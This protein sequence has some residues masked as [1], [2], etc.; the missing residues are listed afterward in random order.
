M[1]F[2]R[3]LLRESAFLVGPTA[4]GKSDLALA[5]A[6][7]LR[8]AGRPVEIVALDSMTLYR[9]LDI[10]TAKP[11]PADRADFPHHLLDLVDPSEEF[12]VAT[13]VA[14]AEVAVR[15][16][17]DRG[18]LPLF[19]GGSGL[20][21]RTL[22]RGLFDGPEADWDLRRRLD[23]TARSEGPEAF[24]AR[25]AAVDP[26]TA[27]RLHPNDLRRIIRALEVHELTGK[28][29][30]DWHQEQPLPP[31]ERP[32]L[33]VW[34]DPDRDW[35]ADRIDRRVDAMLAAGL[36]DETRSV[37]DRI[38][39]GR[40][41]SQ[42]LGYAE[43]LAHLGRAMSLDDCRDAIQTHTR[44]FAKRQCTWF[45]NLEELQPLPL[46]AQSSL[47]TLLDQLLALAQRQPS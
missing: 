26:P 8:S 44:Q 13:Y 19:V 42:S 30:S 18:A 39:F 41:A 5:L 9:H 28:P 2:D 3:H 24:H 6:R 4:A 43:V 37:R 35:L 36:V 32:R 34:L 46:T 7:S 45:R 27:A 38:G 14:A 17:L 15:G 16:I 33:L 47:T 31:E 23:E 12:T 40:T 21:L 11:T 1:R 20:Y 22:L 10:G 29:L 25:L